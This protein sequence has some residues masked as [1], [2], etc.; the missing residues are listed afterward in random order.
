M[1]AILVCHSSL[2]FIAAHGRKEIG[3]AVDEAQ[4]HILIALESGRAARVKNV[5]VSGGLTLTLT[6]N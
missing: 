3:G 4:P 1:V 5:T 2:I 6:E